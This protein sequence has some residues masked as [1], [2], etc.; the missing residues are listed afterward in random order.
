MNQIRIREIKERPVV[1]N[2]HPHNG[3]FPK[4]FFLHSQKFSKLLHIY[5][6]KKRNCFC[7]SN[8]NLTTGV[9]ISGKNIDYALSVQQQKKNCTSFFT[10]VD[11]LANTNWKLRLLKRG[12]LILILIIMHDDI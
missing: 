10:L 7:T 2:A 6:N 4:K 11:S 8:D 3:Y 12:I 1:R 5:E 9:S